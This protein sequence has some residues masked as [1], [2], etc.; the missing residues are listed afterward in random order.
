M[1][2]VMNAFQPHHPS[3]LHG[4]CGKEHR[5][6]YDSLLMLAAVTCGPIRF[7]NE[8]LVYWRRHPQATSYLSSSHYSLLKGLVSAVQTLSNKDKRKI[9]QRYF[10]AL[11]DYPFTDYAAAKII[12]CMK[13]G[14]Y[15][16]FC[17]AVCSAAT[18]VNSFIPITTRCNHV[19]SHFHTIVFHS[20][21]QP[22]HHLLKS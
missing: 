14:I 11:S 19:S 2:P 13:K 3:A 4:S 7:I 18:T 9:T 8:A 5:I 10:M 22:V 17:K 12:R 16:A 20:R 1:C 21:L 15:G 6:S